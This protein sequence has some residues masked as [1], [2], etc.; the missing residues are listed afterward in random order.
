MLLKLNNYDEL[1]STFK[2]SIPEF[3]NI[4]SDTVDKQSYSNRLAL[5][6][7]LDSG[8]LEK[9]SFLDI[10][11]SANKLANAFDHLNLKYNARVGIILGQCPE[12]AISHMACF[13]SGRISIPLF[14]LFGI[15]GLYYRLKNS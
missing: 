6:N 11:K 2:W 14:S 5:L 8:E 1:Y 9:W 7:F 15:D 13:K 10:R 3:Y 4:A 12:T